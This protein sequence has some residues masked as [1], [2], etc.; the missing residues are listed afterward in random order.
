MFL[1]FPLHAHRHPAMQALD[2]KN[3]LI[4]VRKI[5][6]WPVPAFAVHPHRYHMFHLV[7]SSTFAMN[8]RTRDSLIERPDSSAI[9]A[10]HM[11]KSLIFSF[12]CP[13][14]FHIFQLFVLHISINS[15]PKTGQGRQYL[16]HPCDTSCNAQIYVMP[17]FRSITDFHYFNLQPAAKSCIMNLS[18]NYAAFPRWA[19]GLWLPAIFLP[20][21]RS[22]P[23]YALRP[24]GLYNCALSFS[25]SRTSLPDHYFLRSMGTC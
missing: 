5:P 22:A 19:G 21:S 14:F 1:W 7:I 24:P 10:F 11:K 3:P 2:I 20:C 18:I 16:W 8:I 6:H 13:Y 4:P 9:R 15:S 12:P 25:G 17:V 23:L